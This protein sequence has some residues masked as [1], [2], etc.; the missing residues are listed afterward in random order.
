[1]ATSA[2]SLAALRAKT[3]AAEDASKN[4]GK[5]SDLLAGINQIPQGMP[6]FD[7]AKFKQE[8][9]EEIAPAAEI[10]LARGLSK[11][12]QSSLNQIGSNP[13]GSMTQF[14]TNFGGGTID[15]EGK[16]YQLP[17]TT[18]DPVLIMRIKMAYNVGALNSN[19]KMRLV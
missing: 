4:K 2:K 6:E 15:V 8:V 1:M 11:I 16:Q 9:Q 7:E 14:Y 5:L 18:Q 12:P 17:L 3:Q 13:S 10:P 19:I